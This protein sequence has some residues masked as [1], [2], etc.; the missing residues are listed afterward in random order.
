M[1][2]TLSALMLIFLCLIG[3]PKAQAYGS[4]N[5]ELNL[6]LLKFDRETSGPTLGDTTEKWTLYDLKLGY[7]FQNNIYLGAIYSGYT[8]DT[9]GNTNKRNML[10]GT[11]G[12]HNEGW[13]I[14]GSYLFDAKLDWGGSSLKS[15]SGYAI[16]VGYN[17]MMGTNFYLGV[18]A[19]YKSISYSKRDSVSETNKEKSELYPM[20]NL[21]I[22]F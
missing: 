4:N 13:Y 21:G 20:L 6:S 1:K 8:D 11:I 19:S 10:G 5:V 14:D 7:V 18:Q 16:D 12:Y 15:G 9:G 22:M 3:V 17:V 2:T